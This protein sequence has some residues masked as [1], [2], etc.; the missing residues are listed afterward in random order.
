MMVALVYNTGFLVSSTCF[1]SR[2]FFFSLRLRFVSPS[3][4]T[5]AT[6]IRH[7]TPPRNLLPASIFRLFHSLQLLPYIMCLRH[8]L[9]LLFYIY[10][11]FRTEHT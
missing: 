11:L 1:F 8:R 4:H 9:L 3:L 5:H 10:F 2:F 7:K 6:H